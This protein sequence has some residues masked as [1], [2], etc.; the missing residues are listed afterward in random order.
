[1]DFVSRKEETRRSIFEAVD[2][3]IYDQGRK[4]E[5]DGNN[6]RVDNRS[7]RSLRF[8]REGRRYEEGTER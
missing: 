2:E 5:N 3:E 7:T 4:E 1:M 8:F 6:E